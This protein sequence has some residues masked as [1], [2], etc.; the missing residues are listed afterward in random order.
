MVIK[1]K[2]GILYLWLL[3]ASQSLS[4]GVDQK[5]ERT[6][7]TYTKEE[8][9]NNCHHSRSRQTLSHLNTGRAGLVPGGQ[10]LFMLS[11]KKS[12]YKTVHTML[13]YIYVQSEGSV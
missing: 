2:Y 7:V 9:K 5:R 13:V 4:E 12:K 1:I 10:Q 6:I 3:R 11:L 8:R